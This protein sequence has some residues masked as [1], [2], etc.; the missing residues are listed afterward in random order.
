MKNLNYRYSKAIGVYKVCAIAIF[1]QRGFLFDSA[2]EQYADV[3]VEQFADAETDDRKTLRQIIEEM[4][5]TMEKQD[6][7]YYS[8]FHG[9]ENRKFHD[10]LALKKVCEVGATCK[11]TAATCQTK[12]EIHFDDLQ[13]AATFCVYGRLGILADDLTQRMKSNG[14]LKFLI[15][16]LH[17]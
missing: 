9:T 4:P 17:L 13:A 16:A 11:K 12:G 5:A 15:F 7:K 6:T 2:I 10:Q 8:V 1:R 14:F 3:L